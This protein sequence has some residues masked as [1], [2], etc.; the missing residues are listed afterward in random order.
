MEDFLE[1]PYIFKCGKNTAKLWME[2]QGLK[3]KEKTINEIKA[4][5]QEVETEIEAFRIKY[6][7]LFN[8]D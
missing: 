6:F 5:I 2:F 8:T 7:G 4:K 3:N 1:E